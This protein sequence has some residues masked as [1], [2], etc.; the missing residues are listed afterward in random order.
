[1][2]S[3]RSYVKNILRAKSG[4]LPSVLVLVAVFEAMT[5]LSLYTHIVKHMH[6][7]GPR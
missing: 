6:K 2:N 3:G 4:K 7:P 5:F 1:M